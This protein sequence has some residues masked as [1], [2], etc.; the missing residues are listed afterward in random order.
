MRRNLTCLHGECFKTWDFH[1]HYLQKV[2]FS[3]INSRALKKA[4]PQNEL[5][6]AKELTKN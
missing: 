2:P 5:Y 3:S 1:R 4:K 6:P